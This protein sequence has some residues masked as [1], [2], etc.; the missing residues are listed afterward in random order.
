MVT[1][2][3]LLSSSLLDL[4]ILSFDSISR[5]YYIHLFSLILI[6]SFLISSHILIHS[7]QQIKT[8]LPVVFHFMLNVLRRIHMHQVIHMI[9]TAMRSFLIYPLVIVVFIIIFS[10]LSHLIVSV[11]IINVLLIILM[12]FYLFYSYY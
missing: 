7:G 12:I 3:A 2:L 5:S 9:L 4:F 11:I 6:I 10:F 8:H 1:Y